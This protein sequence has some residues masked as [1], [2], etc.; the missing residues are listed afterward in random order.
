MR[1]L[2]Q[3][4]FRFYFI[5]CLSKEW[6]TFKSYMC[7]IL[8]LEFWGLKH[9]KCRKVGA[10]GPE[11]FPSTYALKDE[12]ICGTQC[13][14]YPR[15]GLL[16]GFP[17]G[18]ALATICIWPHYGHGARSLLP[19]TGSDID[20]EITYSDSFYVTCE[21]KLIVPCFSSLCRHFSPNLSLP[22]YHWISRKWNIC[23][24]PQHVQP[25]K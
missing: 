24:D 25:R 18:A 22:G 6:A 1:L 8:H 14:R 16:P 19:A 2:T 20:T 4:L 10:T 7:L 21:C 5:F 17:T 9:H 3:K 15:S 23:S 12:G 11:H 13:T